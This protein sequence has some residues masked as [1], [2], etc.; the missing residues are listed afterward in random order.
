MKITIIGWN[1]KDQIEREIVSYWPEE[2]DVNV[3]IARASRQADVVLVE[4]VLVEREG[5]IDTIV[6][7]DGERIEE[8]RI[9]GNTIETPP[10]NT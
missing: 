7:P 5:E 4:K 6:I 2:L 9:I 1:A 10:D 8:T 3:V